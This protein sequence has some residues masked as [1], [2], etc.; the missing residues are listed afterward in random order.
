MKKQYRNAI[1]IIGVMLIIGILLGNIIITNIQN[2]KISIEPTTQAKSVVYLEK[3]IVI[4]HFTDEGA[5]ISSGGRFLDHISTEIVT[6]PQLHNS[7]GPT[8]VPTQTEEI[9]PETSTKKEVATEELTTKKKVDT[10]ETT[11][12]ESTTAP[13]LIINVDSYVCDANEIYYT[14]PVRK[15]TENQKELIAKMLYCEARGESWDGQVATCS[16]I[17]NHIEYN[18]G[19]F[20][21]LDKTNHF[22][23]ASYYRYRTP[24][25]MQYDVLEYVLSGHLIADIKYFQ[26]DYYHDF[27][28]PMFVVGV[29]YFSK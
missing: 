21:V 16:A 27:A 12:E 11:T 6:H 9:I 8:V 5:I 20:S 28:T 24:N 7:A 15:Y 26:M 22:S 25:Q 29:H 19:D 1:A 13:E 3:P 17:I 10:E 2:S 23:P 14:V 18:D 4:K